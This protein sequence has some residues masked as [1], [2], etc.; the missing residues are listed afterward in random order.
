M[1][2]DTFIPSYSGISLYQKSGHKPLSYPPAGIPFQSFPAFYLRPLNQATSLIRLRSEPHL[3]R[4]IPTVATNKCFDS[5][6]KGQVI[7][8]PKTS[9][10]LLLIYHRKRTLWESAKFGQTP[11]ILPD[12]DIA[13]F[14]LCDQVTHNQPKMHSIS[15]IV[16][17]GPP[18][19]SMYC[20]DLTG[21]NC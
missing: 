15:I 21:V 19:V 5:L 12:D 8:S 6:R 10:A 18:Y 7:A 14:Y 11:W 1:L 9:H 20:N 17:K 3:Q 2:S 4:T 16:W 13:W